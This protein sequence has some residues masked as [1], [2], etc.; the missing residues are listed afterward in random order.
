M[1]VSHST[2]TVQLS[3]LCNVQ[4]VQSRKRLIEDITLSLA[5]RPLSLQ[6]GESIL[7]QEAIKEALSPP[8]LPP[9]CPGL[10]R[11]SSFSLHLPPPP[12]TSL[13]LL[14]DH[15]DF[16]YIICICEDEE[17][18][19]TCLEKAS[20]S[21]TPLPRRLLL[22]PPTTAS[23]HLLLALPNPEVCAGNSCPPRPPAC[24]RPGASWEG[25]NV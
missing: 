4:Y 5:R 10:P 25:S 18:P 15:F 3:T 12:S 13:L 21:S 1:S 24:P 22:K 8:S 7:R 2:H 14:S 11:F 9:I 23:L 19:H 20:P 16:F 17:S 6:L